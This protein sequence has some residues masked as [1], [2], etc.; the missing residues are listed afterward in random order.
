MG[1][2]IPKVALISGHKD[3]KMLMRYTHLR[4][5]DL[6][7]KPN[8]ELAFV[9]VLSDAFIRY[10]TGSKVDHQQGLTDISLTA[11][12][13]KKCKS[14]VDITYTII[15]DM[16]SEGPCFTITIS[17]SKTPIRQTWIWCYETQ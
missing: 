11:T 1:L 17:S 16:R 7:K 10:A 15:L 12:K 14:M 8:M 4:A 5:E 3:V 2:S 9:M 6:A 13:K